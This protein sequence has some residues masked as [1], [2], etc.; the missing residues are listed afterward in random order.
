MRLQVTLNGM[1]G[2]SMMSLLDAARTLPLIL[3]RR[4]SE[5]AGQHGSTYLVAAHAALVHILGDDGGVQHVR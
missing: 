5:L 1:N 4:E 2:A 3:K